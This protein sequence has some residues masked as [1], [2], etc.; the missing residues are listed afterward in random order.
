M[1]SIGN[2]I[3]D[4]RKKHDLT[5]EELAEQLNISSQA[6]SKWENG[7]CMPDISQIIPLVKIFGITSDELL[8][9]SDESENEAVDAL[10]KECQEYIRI[11]H[12]SDKMLEIHNKCNDMLDKYPNNMR[13]LSYTIGHIAI[14]AGEL[15]DKNE[16]NTDEINKLY[17]EA[18]RRANLVVK[19]S[20]D[21]A[22]I[23]DAKQWLVRIYCSLREFDLAREWADRFPDD[24]FY[25]RGIQLAW[26]YD[27]EKDRDNEIKLHCKN[28]SAL[29]DTMAQEI[30]VLG[31]TYLIKENYKD[32]I[33]TYETI[34]K[35][36]DAVYRCGEYT[37]PL[38]A[39]ISVYV[40]LA[41]CYI[42]IG[43]TQD[44]LNYL[45]NGFEYVCNIEKHYNK[46]NHIDNPMLRG[47]E[48]RYLGNKY[49]GRS[50]LKDYMNLSWFD[51][52]R[53]D[54]RFVAIYEQL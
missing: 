29:I 4:L 11:G 42:Q 39:I 52:V 1:N 7:V 13:L 41:N 10:I 17:K 40:F 23:M 43:D 46:V 45:E 16:N 37:P 54:E 50:E 26:I 12:Y 30:E 3:K 24:F 27:S 36:K 51:S 20:K 28:I 8:G 53:E 47:T 14:L 32:A 33:Y 31:G 34:L 19:Y 38:H 5:Q 21:I 49:N 35:I 2:R 18:I 9:I 44:A 6:V 15:A 22:Q 25:N 48:Y